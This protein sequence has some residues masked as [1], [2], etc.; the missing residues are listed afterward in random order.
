M[1]NKTFIMANLTKDPELNHSST[2]TPVCSLRIVSNYRYT[3]KS[4]ENKEQVLFINA[5]VFGRRAENCAK[6]LKKG[7]QIFIE[8][9]LV[10]RTWE[11][12]QGNKRS[13]IDLQT[14]FIQFLDRTKEGTSLE[15]NG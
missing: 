12:P 8:G 7:S 3:T 15:N 11:D 6:Y 2:G 1:F 9:R 10:T 14:E 5:I 4:Q 13:S